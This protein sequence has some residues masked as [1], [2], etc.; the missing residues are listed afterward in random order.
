MELGRP[1]ESRRRLNDFVLYGEKRATAGLLALD[2]EAE[3][4]AIEQV[5]ERLALVDD[6]GHPI[7]TLEVTEVVV[8]RFVDVP[9]EFAQAEGEGFTS[10][11][12]W[13]DGHRA[14]WSGDDITVEDDAP[15]VCVHFDLV[16]DP[17][18]P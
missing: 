14:F 18:T 5:G 17:P 10:I 1:G 9:W 15:V 2:Y 8:R 16:G 6:T 7:A 3:D 4:E 11:D 13:R 12:H